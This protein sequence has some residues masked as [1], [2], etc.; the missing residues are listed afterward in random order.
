MQNLN[1]CWNLHITSPTADQT[2]EG[3]LGRHQEICSNPPKIQPAKSRVIAVPKTAI[4]QVPSAFEHTSPLVLRT[5][6]GLVL[7]IS[8]D[9]SHSPDIPLN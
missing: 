4:S 9:H 6:V 3:V 7:A 2:D 1:K 8:A 5:G